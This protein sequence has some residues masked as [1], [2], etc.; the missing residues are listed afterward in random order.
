MIYGDGIRLRA[1]ERSDLENFVRWLNDPEVIAGLQ[2]YTPL[3]LQEEQAWFDKV[4]EN[5]PAEH[6]MVIEIEREGDWI[7]VGN[8]GVHKI[9]WR[10][11]SAELGIFIGDK[12]RWDQG[13]GTRVMKLLLQYG[14]STLNLNR[15]A[16]E[17]Y[18][19][20]SRAVRTYEKAG[21]VLEGRKRQA[22]YRHGKYSDVLIMSVLRSEWQEE[23]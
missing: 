2:I 20:N 10:I 14:F 8:C 17:V 11:R 15:I 7:P 3:S 19:S 4:L 22:A 13:I 18:D 9:D 6:P 5:H 21:F 23:I 12:S 1:P 16:L